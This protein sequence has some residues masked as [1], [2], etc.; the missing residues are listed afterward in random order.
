GCAVQPDYKRP[1]IELPASWKES[2]AMQ[3]GNWWR[4]YSDPLLEKLV[5]EALARNSDLARA[6]ARVD[7]ARA[8]LRQ[9][10]SYYYPAV[11]ATFGRNRTLSSAATG[12]LPPGVQRERND[13]RA[14]LDVSYEVDLWG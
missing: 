11:D 3:D 4:V 14:T 7:E 5:E 6:M 13:Y 9:S 12:L 1:E 8:L 10:E 2:G